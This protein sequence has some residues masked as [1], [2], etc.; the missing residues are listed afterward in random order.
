MFEW[1]GEN[2]DEQLASSV[3][4]R[5]S[6]L[7][8]S[9]LEFVLSLLQYY[10]AR[11]RDSALYLAILAGGQTPCFCIPRSRRAVSVL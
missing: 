7:S 8:F 9:L 4:S 5:P 11:N 6:P 1:E 2:E 10:V 3:S